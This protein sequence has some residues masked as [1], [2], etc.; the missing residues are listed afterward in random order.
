MSAAAVRDAHG[1][2]PCRACVRTLAC[3]S[4]VRMHDSCAAGGWK[5]G[6]AVA[7]RRSLRVHACLLA[8]ATVFTKRLQCGIL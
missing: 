5:V 3:L 4:P 7:P 1:A 6:G 8:A 2:G